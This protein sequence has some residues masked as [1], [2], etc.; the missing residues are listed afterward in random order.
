MVS[1]L[2]DAKEK[3]RHARR[4]AAERKNCCWSYWHAYLMLSSAEE[5]W[6][7][8]QK[9]GYDMASNLYNSS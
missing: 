9:T 5:K 2:D 6:R 8:A 4:T 1:G 3:Q 7:E